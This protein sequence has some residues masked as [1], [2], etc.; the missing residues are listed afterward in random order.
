M[1]KLLH[2]TLAVC[3]SL[4]WTF[5]SGQPEL[6]SFAGMGSGIPT[7]SLS[8]YQTLGINPANLGWS[9]NG[10]M[11]N[12]GL[13]EVGFMIYSEPLKKAL[14]N[15]LFNKDK[16]FSELEKEEAIRNFT[17]SKLLIS[18]SAMY[19]G[20]SFYDPKIGGFAFNV[21][22]RFFWNSNLNSMS[23][24]FLFKGYNSE[25]F[26]TLI[27]QGDTIGVAKTLQMVS[28]VFRGT[29]IQ[30][31]WLREY[32]FGFGRQ[33]VNNDNFTC[34]AGVG[35]KYLSGYAVFEYGYEN[36]DLVAYSAINPSFE[37]NYSVPSPSLI[38]GNDFQNVGHGFG[39]DVGSTFVIHNRIKL[40]LAV[41]DIGSITWDGNVYRGHD[42]LLE[43]IET[44]GLENYANIYE[45]VSN[46]SLENTDW[47]NWEGLDELTVNLPTNLRAG[48]SYLIGQKAEVGGD[49]YLPLNEEPGNF[50]K[51]IAGVGGRFK[52][53]PWFELSAGIVSGGYFGVAVPLGFSFTPVNRENF[54]W[55]LGL[56]FRD[57]ATLV[58]QENPNVSFGFGLMRFSFGKAGTTAEPSTE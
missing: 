5:S 58:K 13:A 2:L 24:E 21:R 6:S 29:R 14:V 33:L 30:L 45:Q 55:E 51:I 10:K 36:H 25:F 56:A 1:K 52:P 20:V 41:C 9:K 4:S 53:L 7:V 23:A 28:D 40:G 17:D 37:I 19:G 3:L 32:N 42:G 47:G 12:L 38:K 43:T 15:E 26:D 18:L 49:M 16:V 8:D 34:Y 31:H 46:I 11:I 39:F 35:I 44:S 48:A 50:E 27:Q 57:A 22:E 54:S